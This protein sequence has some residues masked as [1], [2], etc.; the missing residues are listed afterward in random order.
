MSTVSVVVVAR[1]E[2]ALLPGCLRRLGFADEVVVVLD[3]RTTDTSA[4]VA[5]TMGAVVSTERFVDFAQFKNAALE[6]ATCDWVLVVDADER[7]TEALEAEVLAAVSAP[8]VERAYRIPIRNVFLGQEMRHGGWTDERPMRLFPRGIRYEGT[9]HEVPALPDNFA[10]Y[11]LSAGLVHFSHRS[12]LDNLDKTRRYA[13]LQAD[14]LLA[15]GAP[16][17]TSRRLLWSA[18]R[19]L[20]RRLVRHRGYRDGEAGVAEALYQALSI[21]AVHIRLWEVQQTVPIDERYRALD[22]GVL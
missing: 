7:V 16:R 5:R 8:G 15:A 4:D 2:E 3:D 14:Q 17:M 20:L 11:E 21:A 22:E 12:V 1:D 13:M 10:V 18:L 9:L 19:E 6:R